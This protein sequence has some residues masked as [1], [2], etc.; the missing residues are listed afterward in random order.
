VKAIGNFE[1]SSDADTLTF[2]YV[3]SHGEY[4]SVLLD[5]KFVQHAALLNQID[6]LPGKKVLVMLAC[7]SGSLMKVLEK[8][9]RK[10][11]YV[12]ITSSGSE[13][14]AV[15]WAED[16]LQ[17]ALYNHIWG[18]R[19]LSELVLAQSDKIPL[20]MDKHIPQIRGSFDVVL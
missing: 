13:D 20:G 4:Q 12:L 8:R 9:E 6:R 2:F 18:T 10:D 14:R 19:K 5:K 7:F 1:K 11:D 15:N 16:D 3:T 17:L